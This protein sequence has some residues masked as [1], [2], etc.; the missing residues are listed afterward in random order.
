MPSFTVCYYISVI[1]NIK[2]SSLYVYL[3]QFGE[4]HNNLQKPG[5]WD[6]TT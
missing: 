3:F 2:D 1:T 6:P 4:L 5:S